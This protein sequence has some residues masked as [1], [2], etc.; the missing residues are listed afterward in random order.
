MRR[1]A[2]L[3]LLAA[4]L[5]PAARTRR[6]RA[7]TPYAQW[8]VYRQRHLLILTRRDDGSYAAGKALAGVLARELPASKARVARA[9]HADRVG[10]L[11]STGQLDVAL[12]RPADAAALAA[13]AAPF[14]GYG[15]VPLRAIVAA[16]EYL[17]VCR[18][19]FPE[20]HA[21]LLAEALLGHGG[22]LALPVRGPGGATV[23]THPGAAAFLA[24]APVPAQ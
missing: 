2:L 1:R 9:P 13:G 11:M 7:H 8:K 15:A 12:M 16:G 5:V 23:P 10:S 22:D 6:A 21:Y 20:A 17:L 19:D 24:G 18:A 4:A 14:A 3:G